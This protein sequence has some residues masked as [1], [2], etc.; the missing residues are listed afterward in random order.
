[1]RL[2]LLHTYIK[3]FSIMIE[4]L[5]GIA[6]IKEVSELKKGSKKTVDE[7]NKKYVTRSKK[8]NPSVATKGNKM[9]GTSEDSE[10]E[11]TIE[12]YRS[13]L[14]AMNE[15]IR[16]LAN[17]FDPYNK[18]KFE[19][20]S[21]WKHPE[22]LLMLQSILQEDESYP[23]EKVSSANV[24]DYLETRDTIALKNA[25]ANGIEDS[26]LNF[27]K[28]SP[29]MLEALSK[30][31]VKTLKDFA[32]CADWELLGKAELVDGKPN[33]TVGILNK[34]GIS[35]K[36]V[37]NLRMTA[38]TQL[39]WLDPSDLESGDNVIKSKV[40]NE[41]DEFFKIENLDNFNSI[42]L[43][44][45]ITVNDIDNIRERNKENGFLLNKL[46]PITEEETEILAKK[47][48]KIKNIETLEN[49]FQRSRHSLVTMLGKQGVS[50]YS[51][52][53]CSSC[54]G[55]VETARL[56]VQPTTNLC[57]DCVS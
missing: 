1:M 26:L 57:M 27:E 20:T 23:K 40:L 47:Y 19:K 18:D 25:R 3:H 11:L 55:F 35:L 48:E 54:N 42:S 17:G 43:T 6:K 24:G 38:R 14:R 8:F 33:E 41:E 7:K 37:Q 51:K 49:Y 39:E 9:M 32:S 36:E 45:K 2:K 29:Q 13:R 16:A 15:S 31:D 4:S 46:L 44:K 56:E 53:H 28:L 10:V 34:F 50:Y 5:V 12:Y 52:T 22:V 21:V 30:N